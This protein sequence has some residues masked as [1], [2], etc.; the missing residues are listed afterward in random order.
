VSPTRPKAATAA[1]ARERQK[2]GASRT[3]RQSIRRSVSIVCNI[4]R[5]VSHCRAAPRSHE[6]TRRERIP[7]LPPPLQAVHRDTLTHTL[8]LMH[9]STQKKHRQSGKGREAKKDSHSL[10]LTHT[11]TERETQRETGATA[12]GG[13]QDGPRQRSPWLLCLPL[14]PR[15]PSSR[16]TAAA[17]P[18][19]TPAALRRQ[20]CRSR[21]WIR[22]EYGKLTEE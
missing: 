12:C 18:A 16:P 17:R 15:A 8:T 2:N 9:P 5:T 3:S 7:P 20:P 11:H 14:P 10:S 19:A 6:P 22:W 1:E 4:P 13:G 21:R